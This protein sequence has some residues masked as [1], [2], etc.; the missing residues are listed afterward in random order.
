MDYSE[1]V[2]RIEYQFLEGVYLTR[3]WRYGRP[4]NEEGDKLP[5]VARYFRKALGLTAVHSLI[6]EHSY[7]TYAG[8]YR[9][10]R[11]RYLLAGR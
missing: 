5:L 2:Q 7:P 8:A 4:D 3:E 6:V 11:I 9:A 1:T 10:L